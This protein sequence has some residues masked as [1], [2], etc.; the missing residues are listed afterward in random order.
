MSIHVALYHRTTYRYDRPVSVGPQTI[1]LRPAAH[2]RTPLL[3]YGM[4]VSPEDHFRNWQQDPLGNPQAR[5]VFSDHIDHFEIEVNLIAD[6][7]V[8]NPFDFFIEEESD[9]MPTVYPEDLRR[10]L[11]PYLEV[12]EESEN[13]R[14]DNWVATLPK[15]SDRMVDF[16]VEINGRTQSRVDYTVRMEPGVQTPGETLKLGRGSCRD[17]AWLMVQS[18]RRLGL[19]ARFASGYLIQLT[20]DVRPIEGPQGPTEDF[21]DL[22]AWAEVFVPGAGWIGLDPT[23]GLLC[24]E[25]HIPLAC[26]PH[27]SSAAP[28]SG[29][30]EAC[31][32]SFEHEMRLTRHHE[33]ARVTKP[34]DESTWQQLLACGDAI[35]R[36]LEAGDVRL[37]M[38]G[39]PTFVSI[40]DMDDPQWTTDAVGPEKR[41]LSGKLLHRLREQFGRGGLLHH[42]EGK[43]YPG[44]SLPRWALACYWRKD[45]LPIWNDDR[46]F[47]DEAVDGGRTVADAHTFIAALASELG[48]DPDRSFA[49]HEDVFH[50]L[51]KENRLP[52][53]MDPTDPK[54]DDPNERSMMMRTFQNGLTSPVGYVMPLQRAWWQARPGWISG[55]WPV[56]ADNVFLLPGD[57]PI[58]LRLPLDTL[59]TADPNRMS[60]TQTPRDP[61]QN[62]EPLEQ[63]MQRMR[64][65]M[66]E[67]DV[68]VTET[69]RQNARGGTAANAPSD[70]VGTFDADDPVVRTALCVQCRGGQL[71]VFM[72][73]TQRLEDYLDLVSAIEQT[74]QSTGIP[75]LIEGYPPPP[76]DRLEVFKITPDPGV[77]EVNMH[78]ASSWR[79]CVD[80]TET[81][82]EQARQTRLGTDKFDL[83][84]RHTGTGG[85]NHIVVGA[86]RPLDSPFLRRP[87]LLASMVA[88]WHNHPSLSYLFGGKFIGPTSQA[89]RVDESRRDAARE[90]QIAMEH[91]PQRGDAFFAW[92]VDRLFRDLLTDLTGNTHRAEICIDKLYS[93]DSVSGRLGLVELR[94]FEMPPHPRMSLATTLLVRGIIAAFWDDPYIDPVVDW[95]N[96]LHDRF[97]LSSFVRDDFESALATL[98]TR[99]V[100]LDREW[101]DPQFEFR[102]PPIGNLSRDGVT[103]RLRDAIEPWYVMGEE[104]GGGG[105]VRFVDSSLERLE[106]MLA[107]DAEHRF[108][109]RCNNVNIPLHRID[110]SSDRV[111]GVKFRAW[112][113]PRCLHPTIGIHSPLRFEIVD[114]HQNVSL[115]GCT[116]HVVHPGGLGTDRFPINASEAESRRAARFEADGLSDPRSLSEAPIPSVPPHMAG[117]PDQVTLDMRT[118]R[119]S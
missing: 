17:S 63:A 35:E 119:W 7:T 49:V 44:E 31:E 48:I 89:P 80:S 79:E 111:A 38:G 83:D 58:G 98:A 100:T 46:W 12:V 8:I 11:S 101:F 41:V 95:G 4:R 21:C 115:G 20:A 56:R 108:A 51:W 19:A 78:P 10:Q 92:Q 116:Y 53:D 5:V 60:W 88:F 42:G 36:K 67:L 43:W 55:R 90:L 75:V 96:R 15:T 24:G 68:R 84:G 27:Y 2:A 104:P 106:V 25:G 1:R 97:L 105:T 99:G 114:T 39:E 40:D 26:T 33:D 102:F 82:Y 52:V 59:P 65:A 85:G 30:L 61:T 3:S 91:M 32:V 66:S 73:P 107:G 76:D 62:R 45:G 71:Y 77:I 81:L 72:P 70:E 117:P 50:Y 37:T 74:C 13:D 6:M 47:A 14:L 109:V 110:S 94:G 16:L 69:Q 118:V 87:D 18:M 57:S 29:S 103:L 23:S 28:I 54:L 86:S 64:Q 113:P 93:P 22:H 112:Q 9:C 34:Y